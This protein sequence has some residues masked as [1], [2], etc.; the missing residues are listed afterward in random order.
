MCEWISACVTAV[1]KKKNCAEF[2]FYCRACVSSQYTC[3]YNGFILF[4]IWVFVRGQNTISRGWVWDLEGGVLQVMKLLLLEGISS[5]AVLQVL[6]EFTPF[7][8]IFFF[9]VNDNNAQRP[10]FGRPERLLYASVLMASPWVFYRCRSVC[11]RKPERKPT[12]NN[13]IIIYLY[14]LSVFCVFVLF[15]AR[16]DRRANGVFIDLLLLLLWP[17][18][19]I[20]IIIYYDCCPKRRT[21]ISGCVESV[22]VRYVIA[23]VR[24]LTRVTGQQSIEW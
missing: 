10:V 18:V 24:S 12:R 11:I 19:L 15:H 5:P 13:I 9:F 14:V 22:F 7:F 1:K 8:R 3:Q 2:R 21:N 23:I 17:H 20:R 16:C 4:I 6:L